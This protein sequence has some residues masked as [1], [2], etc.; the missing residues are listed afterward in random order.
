MAFG[1][2]LLNGGPF[3]PEGLRSTTFCFAKELISPPSDPY[4]ETAKWVSKQV[5]ENASIWVQPD[6]MTYSLIYH[7]P[8][9]IY[10]WQLGWPPEPQFRGLPAIQFK[11]RIPPDYIICFGPAVRDVVRLF[12]LWA[13]QGVQYEYAATIDFF[14]KD[15][16]R[17]ELFWRSFTPT[18]NYKKDQEAIYVFE[19]AVSAQ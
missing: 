1:T 8:K 7:A 15:Q 5:P 6:Y 9:A 11:G 10:A 2:N 3:S 17:P 18:V 13:K 19:R 14:Y 12:Q 4:T 16:Y